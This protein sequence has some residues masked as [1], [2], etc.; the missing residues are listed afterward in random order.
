MNNQSNIKN[1][2]PKLDQIEIFAKHGGKRAG[3]GRKKTS[4]GSVV[5]RIPMECVDAVNAVIAAHKS[6]NPIASLKPVTT[7]KQESQTATVVAAVRWQDK[8]VNPNNP[9]EFWSGRGR[10]PAWVYPH[11][12]GKTAPSI[13]DS[14]L[15]PNPQI[16][17]KR[18]FN[19]GDN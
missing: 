19:Q 9:A 12:T 2:R 6:G 13:P 17:L 14:L 11:M 16:P 4:A 5:M 3:S 7:I 15:N 10:I 1:K 18:Y 8:Y